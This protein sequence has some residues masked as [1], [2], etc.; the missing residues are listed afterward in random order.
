MKTILPATVLL[1]LAAGC[2][3]G[4]SAP[5][6]SGRGTP[7]ADPAAIVAA[8]RAAGTTGNELEVQPLRDP[9]VQD[10]RDQAE[11]LEERGDRK[12]AEALLDQ[13][14]AISVDDPDLLQWKA[15]L[16][17]YRKDRAATEQLAAR[18]FERGP[19]LGGLC[20][21]NWIAIQHART[22]RG[23]AAGATAARARVDDCTVAPP[24]RM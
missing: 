23:D 11:A 6:S 10:L 14:L 24:V 19:K 1:L 5:A 20:R 18:S 12:R 7:R 4:P 22:G 9:Q 16:A 15:E 17:I 21:R 8:V 3:S 13:A 2:T